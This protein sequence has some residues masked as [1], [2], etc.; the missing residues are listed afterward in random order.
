MGFVKWMVAGTLILCVVGSVQAAE[1][2]ETLPGYVDAETILAGAHP[3]VQIC[4]KGSRL[5]VLSTIVRHEEPELGEALSGLGLIR[6]FVFE[7]SRAV[8]PKNIEKTTA[9]LEEKGWE[10]IV[11]VS[12]EAWDFYMTCWKSRT[13]DLESLADVAVSPSQDES[14]R[15]L[16]P[17][18]GSLRDRH[19]EV[20]G[21]KVLGETTKAEGPDVDTPSMETEKPDEGNRDWVVW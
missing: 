13:P 1:D 12:D 5:S 20:S 2:I 11:Q 15:S 6:V 10:K 19:A 7:N 8:K 3:T 14:S 21:A 17:P 18:E 9:R 16:S 4:L